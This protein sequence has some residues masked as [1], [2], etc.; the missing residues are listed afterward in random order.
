VTFT[1]GDFD[2]LLTQ[3]I[4][5][6]PTWDLDVIIEGKA[7]TKGSGRARI[8]KAAG[9]PAYAFFVPANPG[10]QR[11]WSAIVAGMV[12][13]QWID[14]DGRPRD[15]EP[16]HVGIEV[17]AEFVLPRSRTTPADTPRHTTTPDVDKLARCL[18]DALTG[19]VYV[20]DSQADRFYAAKRYA[21]P[22]EEP[23]VRLRV[24]VGGA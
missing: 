3:A 2:Y 7:I 18:G 4:G 22:D 19:L 21:E 6:E 10:D 16:R 9:Q 13:A 15:P 20:D 17:D 14:G 11:R 1:A 12:R 23:H 24:R 5:D 8:A